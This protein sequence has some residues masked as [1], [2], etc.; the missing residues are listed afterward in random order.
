MPDPTVEQIEERVRQR[1]VA[2]GPRFTI[3]DEDW[4]L[5]SL[6]PFVPRAGEGIRKEDAFTSNR[7]K[8]YANQLAGGIAGAKQIIRVEVDAEQEDQRDQNNNYER[9]AIGALR[10]ADKKRVSEGG[11]PVRTELGFRAIT[12]GMYVAARALLTKDS[13]GETV[14]DVLPIHP[15][16]LLIQPG[17]GEP[18]WAAVVTIRNRSE[19][20]SE[21]PKFKFDD[22]DL[23]SDGQSSEKVIDYYWKQSGGKDNGKYMNAVVVAGKWVR[24]PS[25][26]FATIFPIIARAIGAHSGTSGVMS[27]SENSTGSNTIPGIE[28]WAESAFAPIRA[29]NRFKNRLMSYSMTMTARGIRQVMVVE[30]REGTKELDSAVDEDAQEIGR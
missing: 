9:F 5:Y 22:D 2:M 1:E 26:T 4:R 11:A 27:L 21:Y 17:S 15:R 12:A 23:K 18:Q 30:S 6:E 10:L 16:H 20:R 14:V 19:I 13:K 3:A 29:N 8:I 28:T 24:K 25:D 7:P